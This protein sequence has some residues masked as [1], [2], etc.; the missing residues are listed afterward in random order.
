MITPVHVPFKGPEDSPFIIVAEAPGAHEVKVRELF[1]ADSPPGIVLNAALEQF[2]A[3]TFPEPR[4]ITAIPHF[5][6]AR[7]KNPEIIANAVQQNRQALID[8]IKKHPRK[9]ILT[10]GNAALWG[11][12]GNLEYK[13]TQTRGKRILTPLA[14]QGIIVATHPA[15]LLRGNG[16][17]RQ[18]KA[19]VAY[20]LALVTGQ[21]PREFKVPTWTLLD[22][23]QKVKEFRELMRAHTGLIAG[24][25]ETAGFSHRQDAVLMGGFTVDGEHVYVVPGKKREYIAAGIPDRF[26][27]VA[28]MWESQG[29]FGWHNG[30][31]DIKF[32]RHQY[33]MDARIDE[34]SMLLSYALDETR[35]VHDLE[36]V[37]ND[38]LGSPNW[39]K[40]LDDHKKK[41]DSYDVIPEPVLVKYMA[42]DIANTFN[43]IN[44]LRPLVAADAKSDLLYT[45]TLIPGS[46]YLARIEECGMFV[47]M[48]R[49]EENREALSQEA[50]KYRDQLN[51]LAIESGYGP[52]NPNSPVQLSSFLYNTLKIP[53]KDRGTGEKVLNSLPAHPAIDL[54]K[55]YRKI[56][57]GLSTYV[58]PVTEHVQDDGRVHQS[59][60]IHGTATGR[61]A[62]RDPNLQNIPRDP[63]LRGQFIPQPGY[64]FIEVDLNQ[65]ELRSLAALSGDP[66]LCRIYVDPNSKGLHEEVRAG[67]F[68]M[69]EE[70]S[71]EQLEGYFRRWYTSDL[72]RVLEE[73]KMRAK[74]TNFG[75]IYGITAVGLA[76]QIE[77]SPLEAQ[78]MLTTWAKKFPGAWGF[79]QAC[80]SAPVRGQNL[81][82][83]FGHKKRFG[84]VTPEILGAM[85]NEAANFPH[86]STA[87]TVTLHGGMEIQERLR[88]EYDT[89]IVNTVH[90]SLLLEAPL[91]KTIIDSVCKLTID[92]LEDIPRRWGIT[93][94]PFKA[95]S[96]LGM[97]WGNLMGNERFYALPEVQALLENA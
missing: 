79:I 40:V 20:A 78:H 47:D 94:I 13:V 25:L 35:G 3:G 96:K 44:V 82:T 65:A 31:F 23:D 43:L 22:T 34:D 73:Q 11:V 48:E 42:Y 63:K 95:E 17:F 60:L 57:K 62:C 24:D 89:R 21:P 91:N 33:G 74:N 19:D 90:D 15:Y 55:K 56:Q 38:W 10:L 70:W 9:V 72:D 76:E 84:V 5:I 67:I 80:R 50:Q 77:G 92:T 1:R 83:V 49:V 41:K 29:R 28:D 59:Y 71:Q 58:T 64:C 87:S 30:K 27:E 51:E 86:Q 37:A 26:G 97:R 6:N 93:R 18:F 52:I 2:P 45:K 32:L 61:L 75:I 7:A 8:E 69:P 16:S 53:T 39:K 85:Q 36:T 14:E 4:I 66:E 68:G 88:D 81:V 46:H 12:T 54:L